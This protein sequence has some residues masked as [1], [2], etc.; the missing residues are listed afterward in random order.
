MELKHEDTFFSKD[1]DGFVELFENEMKFDDKK[2]SETDRLTLIAKFA[3]AYELGLI[4]NDL[5]NFLK[6]ILAEQEKQANQAQQLSQYQKSLEAQSKEFEKRAKAEG[7]DKK[8][9]NFSDSLSKI[10]AD[11]RKEAEDFS[12]SMSKISKDMQAEAKKKGIKIVSEDGETQATVTNPED[13][14]IKES[15]AGITNTASSDAASE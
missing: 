11:M 7:L 1:F 3:S 14:S 8:Y 2:M 9:K 10:T 12:K 6:I 5:N 15:Q 13:L 4:H